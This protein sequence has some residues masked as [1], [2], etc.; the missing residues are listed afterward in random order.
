MVIVENMG[1]FSR[2]VTKNGHMRMLLLL[3]VY[4]GLTRLVSFN[5]NK[6]KLMLL[7]SGFHLLTLVIHEES[8]NFKREFSIF[9]CSGTLILCTMNM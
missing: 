9:S 3:S 7:L 4:V 8:I 1:G 2:G 6:I 5:L